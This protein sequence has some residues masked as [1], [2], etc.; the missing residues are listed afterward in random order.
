MLAAAGVL[1][2]ATGLPAWVAISGVAL[3]FSVAGVAMGVFGPDLMLALYPR[4][5][6]LL[7]NDLLQALPLYV[8]M[9]ILLN[10]LPLAGIVFRAA[11]RSLGFTGRGAPLAGLGLGV[12]L[13]PMSGSVGASVAMLART[14]HPRLRAGGVPEDRSIALVCAASTL[15]VVVPPSLVL[16]LLGDAMLRAHTEA[17]NI[18]GLA[19]RI[20]NTQDVFHAA[21][22]PAALL[23]VLFA[24][25]VARQASRQ[26]RGE[27]RLARGEALTAAVTVAAIAVLLGAVAL[28]YFYAVEAAATGGMALVAY[29]VATRTLDREVLAR[30]LEETLV[31][32]GAL[33]ALLVAA[34]FF[35]LVQ[36]A[37]GTDRWLT[38]FFAGLGGGAGPALAIGLAMLAACALVLDAFEMIF[39]VIPLVI[40]PLLTRVPDATW[41][42]VLTLLV[43]QTSFLVPPF[44]YAVLMARGRLD[45]R[46]GTRALGRALAPYVG[47]QLVVLALVLAFPRMLWRDEAEPPARATP[48]SEQR[49]RDLLERQ[50]EEP[51]TEKEKPAR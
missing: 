24:A 45:S 19:G 36:R 34:T 43:L 46:V 49:D 10:R 3:A 44:G 50:L 29:G 47:A 32:T 25:V 2:L 22:V 37:Y 26:P 14:V 7:E 16:I 21:L 42:A 5:V 15:G 8:L 18:V 33:F 28:G 17:A 4:I 13:A 23:L 35:T 30:T 9:G 1:M 12:L 41:V 48:A 27:D 51:E 39:V 38:A 20:I 6:G 31:V 11:V 40:P